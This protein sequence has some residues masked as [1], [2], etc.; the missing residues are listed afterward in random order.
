[1][2]IIPKCQLSVLA[3]LHAKFFQSDSAMSFQACC[4]PPWIWASPSVMT[5]APL[6][7]GM[8]HYHQVL[9]A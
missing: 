4:C 5:V 3:V 1:M 7:T 2:E 8:E 6:G 9:L